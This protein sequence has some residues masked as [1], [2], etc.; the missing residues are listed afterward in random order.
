M[1]HCDWPN[2]KAGQ[3]FKYRNF[4]HKYDFRKLFHRA[5]EDFVLEQAGS[6]GHREPTWK[7]LSGKPKYLSRYNQSIFQMGISLWRVL[8]RI[9]LQDRNIRTQ[10]RKL[11]QKWH[12]FNNISKHRLISYLGFSSSWPFECIWVLASLW[13]SDIS[14]IN[15]GIILRSLQNLPRVFHTL[16]TPM[17]LSESTIAFQ[18]PSFP[19]FDF[20]FSESKRF[21][22][23]L[24]ASNKLLYENVS[25]SDAVF[26]G[27]SN[28]P[29]FEN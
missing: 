13:T 20:D 11:T 12:Y 19:T 5:I 1:P 29:R 14:P 15:E 7:V 22:I 21:L 3:G 26:H 16:K 8:A 6:E 10:R 17:Q 18:N 23:E 9:R 2:G 24:L 25:S 27:A 28:A 4:S